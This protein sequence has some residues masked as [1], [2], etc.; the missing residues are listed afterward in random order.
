MSSSD[1]FPLKPTGGNKK[2][3]HIFLSKWTSSPGSLAFGRNRICSTT[4]PPRHPRE[5]PAV[6]QTGP[7][8]PGREPCEDFAGDLAG[9]LPVNLRGAPYS[10]S[11]VLFL[12]LS[13]R[14]EKIGYQ[15]EAERSLAWEFMSSILGVSHVTCAFEGHFIRVICERD[16]GETRFGLQF[17]LPDS[18]RHTKETEPHKTHAP[19]AYVAKTCRHALLLLSSEQERHIA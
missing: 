4:D 19:C 2:Q 5:R 1:R 10:S 3:Q 7:Q 14:G 16:T 17:P 12:K 11:S 6:G 13:C 15:I 8:L 18:L 9:I